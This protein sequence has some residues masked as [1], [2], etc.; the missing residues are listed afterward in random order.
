MS[1]L[2]CRKGG[3]RELMAHSWFSEVDWEALLRR[4][5][6]PP[7]VPTIAHAFDT[8]RFSPDD[9]GDDEFQEGLVE[10]ATSGSRSPAG[11]IDAYPPF[12]GTET[13]DF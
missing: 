4:Q 5:V 9:D 7:W 3:A 12:E 13:W 1:R 6:S 8:Q 10:G 2:G 11:D